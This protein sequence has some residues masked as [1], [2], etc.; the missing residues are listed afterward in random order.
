MSDGEME[1]HII[2]LMFE[3][4]CSSF[5]VSLEGQIEALATSFDED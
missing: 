3:F 5:M 2:V 4:E 1:Y